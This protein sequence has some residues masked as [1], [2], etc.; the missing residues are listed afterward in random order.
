MSEG[1]TAS[2]AWLPD[3]ASVDGSALATASAPTGRAPLPDL[4]LAP[5]LAVAGLLTVVLIAFSARYGYH[6]DELYFI[7]SGKHLAWGYPDQPRS[8]P[9]SPGC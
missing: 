9:W 8:C 2:P 4:A 1:E 7:A 3:D 5:V 6:R